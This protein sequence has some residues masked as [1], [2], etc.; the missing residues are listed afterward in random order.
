MQLRLPQTRSG[1]LLAVI[2]SFALVGVLGWIDY[3]TG[4][5]LKLAVFYLPS[6][7][8]AVWYGGL[9]AGIAVAGVAGVVSLL[10]DLFAR[11][12]VYGPMLP[13]WNA[14]GIV[15]FFLVTVAL[16]SL[17]RDALSREGALSR[18]DPTTGLANN[19][20]FIEAIGHEIDRSRRSG[21]PFSLVYADCDDF[22]SVN[23]LLGHAAGDAVLRDV[24]QRLKSAVRDIDLAARVGGDEFA[25]LL[26]ESDAAG[27]RAAVERV[28]GALAQ[29]SGPGRVAVTLSLGVA[30]FSGRWPSVEQAIREADRLMFAAKGAGKNTFRAEVVDRG[31][32]PQV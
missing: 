6:I 27:A 24:A 2:G 3:L 1:A 32:A 7:F 25:V 20:A 8:V 11:P 18:E 16:V 28:R 26:P 9:W 15:S 14:L 31:P 12:V 19:R 21:R 13:Y 10:A 4:R 5:D 22:K 17:L 30:T 23:E 29:A